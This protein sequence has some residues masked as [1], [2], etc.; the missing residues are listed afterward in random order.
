MLTLS[1]KSNADDVIRRLQNFRAD[2]MPFATAKA[3][4]DTAGN[5]KRALVEEMPR[6]IDRPTQ[7][8]LGSIYLSKATKDNFMARVGIADRTGGRGVP[9]VKWMYWQVYGGARKRKRFESAL[10]ANG[11]LPDGLMAV[12]GAAARLDANGNVDFKQLTEVLAA[13]KSIKQPAAGGLGRRTGNAR[14]DYFVARSSHLAPGIWQRIHGAKRSVRPVFLYV[15]PPRYGKRYD[16][17]GTAYKAV[18]DNFSRNF[19]N[20]IRYAMRTAR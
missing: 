2:Q 18:V 13:L 4:T 14:V 19:A 12:P 8:T 11:L 9:P 10:R 3:L 5:V 16:F 6:S 17:Y 20:A 7:Y 15:P 1:V